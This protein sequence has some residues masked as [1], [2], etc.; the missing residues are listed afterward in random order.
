MD[1]SLYYK[2]DVKKNVWEKRQRK[3]KVLDWINMVPVGIKVIYLRLLLTHVEIP[4]SF[5]DLLY[6]HDIMHPTYKAACIARGLL[7]DDI[8]WEN[9]L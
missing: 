4:T 7:E 1:L 3:I 8:E 9:C 6:F 5:E 2:W